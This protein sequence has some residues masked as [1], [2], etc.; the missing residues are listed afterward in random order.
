M[1]VTDILNQVEISNFH[2]MSFRTERIRAAEEKLNQ[3][4]GLLR[5]F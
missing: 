4:R 2:L 1:R 5:R 3:D